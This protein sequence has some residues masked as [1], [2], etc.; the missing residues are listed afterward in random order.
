MWLLFEI[1]VL[2]S[3]LYVRKESADDEQPAQDSGAD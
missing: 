1:G 3:R 2:V